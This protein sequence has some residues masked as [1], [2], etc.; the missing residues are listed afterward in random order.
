MAKNFQKMFQEHLKTFQR[1]LDAPDCATEKLSSWTYTD[2][3]REFQSSMETFSENGFV[4]DCIVMA[5]KCAALSLMCHMFGDKER[6]YSMTENAMAITIYANEALKSRKSKDIEWLKR[7]Y[8]ERI[9]EYRNAPT[10]GLILSAEEQAELDR[11]IDSVLTRLDGEN[12]Q[13]DTTR[14][15]VLDCEESDI[16]F[17]TAAR[18]RH[19]VAVP[20]SESD[21][22]LRE[23][24]SERAYKMLTEYERTDKIID[25]DILESQYLA[26]YGLKM[27]DEL[28]EFIELYD[29]RVYAWQDTVFFNMNVPFSC[30]NFDGF[31]I[32]P[33]IEAPIFVSG[34]KYFINAMDFHVSGDWGPYVGSDGKIYEY[35]CGELELPAKSPEEFFEEEAKKYFKDMLLIER[36]RELENKYLVAKIRTASM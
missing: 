33:E 11:D 21:R 10:H 9:S 2:M 15:E 7:L 36:R 1:R 26:P 35:C 18:A 20:P 29:G 30:N 19:R 24:L 6:A 12:P 13:T 14:R 32:L 17:G 22:K 27:T 31:S 16:D 28:R 23:R 5:Y 34:D 8:K 25:A 3:K 4:D